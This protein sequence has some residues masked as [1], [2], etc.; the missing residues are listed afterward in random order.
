MIRLASVVLLATLAAATPTAADEVQLANG[1]RLTGELV[2]LANGTLT[3]STPHGELRI[4]W[5]LVTSLAVETPMLVTV[6]DGPPAAAGSAIGSATT[7]LATGTGG[8]L[9]FADITAITRPVPPVTVDGVANAGFLRSG[10]NSDASSLQLDGNLGVRAGANRYT[11]TASFIRS[12]DRSTETARNWSTSLKYD[13]FLDPRLFLNANALFTGDQFRDLD[14]RTAL[15]AGLGYQ[16]LDTPR[17][18]LTTDAGIGWVNEHRTAGDDNRYTAARESAALD[19]FLILPDRM[20]LFHQHDGYF[21]VTGEDNLFIRTQNGVRL[22]L[23]GG[24]VTT[25]RLGLEYDRTPAPGRRN[26]D[27][28]VAV[29]LGYQ[30]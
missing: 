27:R 3:F 15:G 23:A 6:G 18:R 2:A 1:D 17:V 19:V 14:L 30:F 11:G 13:R 24:L 20:Q 25:M 29:T 9:A 5:N 8:P 26:I 12:E 28:T 22:G 10:G 21:G 7:G 16:V 4:P